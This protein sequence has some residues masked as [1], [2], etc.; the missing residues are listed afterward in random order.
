MFE[1]S[2]A[3]PIFPSHIWLH[4]VAAAAVAPLNQQL[5]ASLEDL[6]GPRPALPPGAT[7]QSEQTLHQYKEFADLVGLVRGA[8]KGVLDA[9]AIIY[10]DFVITGCW[11]NMN[12]PGAPH[13]SHNHPNNLLSG[14][15]YVAV[16]DGVDMI[17]F[18]D[19]RPQ[20]HIIEPRTSQQNEFNQFVHNVQV[21]EGTLAI[22]PAWLPHSV[23]PNN[24]D[25]LR[26]SI[27]FNIMLSDFAETISPPIW[28]GV[29]L[30]RP[31]P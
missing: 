28:S 9:Q 19:P 6:M 31:P 29:K 27:A 18:H 3:L 8:T 24:T 21:R 5:L 10:K 11:A 13:P 4:Q 7:W 20:R 15:Y 14:V 12:P 26:V 25:A 1:Q 22:F 23:I 2:V 16:P 30:R 17:S